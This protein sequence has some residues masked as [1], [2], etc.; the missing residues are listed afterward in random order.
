PRPLACFATGRSLSRRPHP[1]VRGLP[2]LRRVFLERLRQSIV[3]DL[4]DESL[5]FRVPELGLGLSFELG[6][7]DPD[8]NDRGQALAHVV[9]AD[10]ALESLEKPVGLRVAGEGACQRGPEPGEMSAPL[11]RVDVVREREEILLVPVVVLE[12]DLHLDVVLLALEEENLRMDRRLVLIEVLDE[13]DD[14]ALVEEAVAP[15]VA[16]VLDDDLEAL[17]QKGQLAQSIGQRVERERG[18]LEDLRIRLEAD[19]RAVLGGLLA[20]REVALRHP[21]LIS[22]RPHAPVAADLDLEPFAEC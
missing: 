4:L 15:L 10:V 13:L 16:L 18:L 3:D 5:D 17:V 19:D 9:A 1:L 21:V 6:I 11:A 14:A 22:L 7:R 20:G 12:R 8:R 2:S